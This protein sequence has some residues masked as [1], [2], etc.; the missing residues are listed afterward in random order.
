MVAAGPGPQASLAS[1]PLALRGPSIA[2]QV[3]TKAE[4]VPES[5]GLH[6]AFC[7]WSLSTT[8]IAS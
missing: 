2:Q 1:L 4:R 6:A 3:L 5:P 7:V 8:N